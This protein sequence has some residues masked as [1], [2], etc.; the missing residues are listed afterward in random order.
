MYT[1][2]R[3]SNISEDGVSHEMPAPYSPPDSMQMDLDRRASIASQISEQM[4]LS[5]WTDA[6]PTH[7]LAN[8]GAGPGD[9]LL[10][11]SHC[12]FPP[13][14]S[15][16][17]PS[18]LRPARYLQS[19]PASIHT[20]PVPTHTVVQGDL[21]QHFH[22]HSP[23]PP[24]IVPVQ[25]PAFEARSHP[26]ITAPAA[27]PP[28]GAQNFAC[29]NTT[30]S[31]EV[32]R[33]PTWPNSPSSGIGTIALTM[34]Q[35]PVSQMPTPLLDHMDAFAQMSTSSMNSCHPSQR[36]PRPSWDSAISVLSPQM[37]PKEV[38]DMVPAVPGTID[39]KWVG[40]NFR[41]FESLKQTPLL[42][43]APQLGDLVVADSM[44][45]FNQLQTLTDGGTM[46]SQQ[47]DQGLNLNPLQTPDLAALQGD[48]T[49][50][51]QLPLLGTLTFPLREAERRQMESGP[52]ALHLRWS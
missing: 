37:C 27:T 33:S 32:Q 50:Y 30:Y 3:L 12:T 31:S 38:V 17:S 40:P 28:L 24:R 5:P 49:V 34:F 48:P 35:T 45:V 36:A 42:T 21:L 19:C 4:P 51:S 52:S 29:L 23:D 16:A 22:V 41:S 18:Q 7:N 13:P 2:G 1:P 26:T 9:M 46:L 14:P 20:T 15:G 47:S 10:G 25:Q 11:M 6:S 43:P 44:P 8:A 39:P